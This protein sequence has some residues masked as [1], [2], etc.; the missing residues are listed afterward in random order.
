MLDGD[1]WLDSYTEAKL[2][3]P[4]VR[5]LMNKMTFGQVEGWRG[6]GPMRIT[7]RK[8]NGE[9]RFFDTFGGKRNPQLADY[10]YLPDEEVSEKFNRVCAFMKVDP[11]QRDRARNM[12]WNLRQVKDIGQAI[13]TLAKFGQPKPL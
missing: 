1:L 11:A 2:K 7:I 3:D 6:A 13:Q 5:A 10:P 8:K 9:Q 4:A 12:W